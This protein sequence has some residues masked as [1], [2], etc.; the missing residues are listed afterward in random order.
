MSTTIEVADRTFEL[1]KSGREQAEQVVSLGKWMNQYGLPALEGMMNEEGEIVFAGGLDLLQEIIGGLTA[2]ALIDLYIVVLGC[3]K[4]FANEHF[5]IAT[6]IDA[7][8]EVYEA[9]PSLGRVLSRFFSQ[10]TSI[11]D[12]DEPSTTSED[13]TDGPTT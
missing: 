13:T 7:I 9:Q 4:K 10:T 12:S 11:E 2:D 6:L 1:V 8:V 5:D 3:S